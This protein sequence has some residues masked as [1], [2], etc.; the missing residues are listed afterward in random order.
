MYQ[1]EGGVRWLWKNGIEDT[2][3]AKN[4]TECG[5]CEDACPQRL[6]IREDLK[7]VQAEF[8]AICAK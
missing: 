5:Q 3:K 2:A 6:S 4:C 8:D 7:K 1:N